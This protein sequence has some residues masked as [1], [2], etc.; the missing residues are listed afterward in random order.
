[1]DETLMSLSR[2]EDSCSA[3]RILEDYLK[4]DGKPPAASKDTIYHYTSVDVLNEMCK[5]SGD[6]LATH[7]MSLNDSNEFF[8]GVQLALKELEKCP[9]LPARIRAGLPDFQ[10]NA[11]EQIVAF[12]RSE[13]IV[14]WIVSFSQE[15]DSLSQWVSYTDRLRGGVSIGFDRGALQ[16]AVRETMEK[17]HSSNANLTAHLMRCHYTNGDDAEDWLRNAF[18]SVMSKRRNKGMSLGIQKQRLLAAIILCAVAIKNES[19][20]PEQETRLV[21]LA[22]HDAASRRYRFVGG[23]PRIETKLFGWDY[24]MARAISSVVISPQGNRCRLISAVNIL[25]QQHG[26]KF[27]IYVSTSSYNGQ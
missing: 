21:L 24:R 14:P 12:L 3:S 5:E 22:S 7:F 17:T 6:F 2:I 16:T 18:A 26:L 20:S 9:A 11:R 10:K 27:P 1:M 19:F 25:R 4:T 8:L 15:A 13:S 23:K